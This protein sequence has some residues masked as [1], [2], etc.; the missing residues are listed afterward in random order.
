MNEI[1]R[2]S[3]TIN[4]KKYN[5]FDVTINKNTQEVKFTAFE[6]ETLPNSLIVDKEG[7]TSGSYKITITHPN[8]LVEKVS[9]K[10]FIS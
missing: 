5:L 10:G 1:E 4:Q 2:I 3:S 6:L 8:N 7:S 9:L